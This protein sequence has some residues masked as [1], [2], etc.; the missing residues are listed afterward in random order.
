MVE[1]N[2]FLTDGIEINP[3][4]ENM[5]FGFSPAAGDNVENEGHAYAVSNVVHTPGVY[6]VGAK[7]K[8]T[9]RAK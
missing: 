4:F 1:A 6:A 5:H 8:V 7:L 9:L 2:V 3:L